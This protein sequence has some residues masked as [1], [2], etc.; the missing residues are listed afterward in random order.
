M[1]LGNYGHFFLSVCQPHSSLF[2]NFHFPTSLNFY[3]SIFVL[4]SY[5]ISMGPTFI[6]LFHFK[7]EETHCFMPTMY[8]LFQLCIELKSNVSTFIYT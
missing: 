5:L 3:I 1:D 8:S 6:L 2:I 7:E 4:M